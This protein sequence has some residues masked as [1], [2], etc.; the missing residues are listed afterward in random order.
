LLEPEPLP[1]PD[2]EPPDEL[3]LPLPLLDMLLELEELLLLED[4][5]PPV[6]VPLPPDE[7]APELPAPELPAPDDAPLPLDAPDEPEGVPSVVLIDDELGGPLEDAP[8]PE[9]ACEL[10]AV[11]VELGVPPVSVLLGVWLWLL[12]SDPEL[13]PGGCWVVAHTGI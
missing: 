12:L 3:L 5:V 1:L 2:D 4:V 13:L 10:D 7:P 11:S 9:L 8:L 6:P